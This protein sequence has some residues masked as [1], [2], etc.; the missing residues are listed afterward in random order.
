L[1]NAQLAYIAGFLDGDGCIASN[2]EKSKTC[3]LGYRVRI[4]I[5]FTQARYRRQVLDTLLS[6]IQSGVIAEYSH[7]EMAEYVIRDQ[8]VVEQLLQL[9]LPYLIVKKQHAALALQ[10]FLLKKDRYTPE[11]LEKMRQLTLTLRSFNHYPKRVS[12]DPVTTEA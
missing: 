5:S 7:N 3:T 2:F 1:D 8:V 9:L 10:I 11:S 12:L 4:R 6:W